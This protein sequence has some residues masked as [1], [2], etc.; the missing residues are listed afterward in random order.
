M[1]VGGLLGCC[2]G[3]V[4]RCGCVLVNG[5]LGRWVSVGVC[6]CVGVFVSGCLVAC[7]SVC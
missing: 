5:F 7:G 3:S 6:V 4:S 1:C 2:V